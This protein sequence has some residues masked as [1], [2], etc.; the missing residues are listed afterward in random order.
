MWKH[1]SQNCDM[2]CEMWYVK[3]GTIACNLQEK[4]QK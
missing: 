3:S 1:K 2:T 4:E